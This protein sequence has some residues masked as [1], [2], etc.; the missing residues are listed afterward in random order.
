MRHTQ[1]MTRNT[2]KNVAKSRL[3]PTFGDNKKGL[4]L[5]RVGLKVYIRGTES[6]W[7]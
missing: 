2:Q 1:H 5:W 3:L 7:Q 6:A 4:G